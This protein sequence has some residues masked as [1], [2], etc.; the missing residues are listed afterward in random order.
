MGRGMMDKMKMETKDVTLE[1]IKRIGELF[2]SVVTEVMDPLTKR[3]NIAVDFDALKQILSGTIIEGGSERYNFTWPGKKEAIIEANRPIRKTLRPCME[4]SRNWDDTKNIFIEGDNLDALKLLQES[5]LNTVKMI[6]ID[7]P[8]N[9]G[10]DFIYNDNFSMGQ[11]KFYIANHTIDDIGNRMIHNADSNGRFHSDWCSMIYPRIKLAR[12]LL[13]DDGVIFISIDDNEQANTKKILDEVFGESNF[14]AN[15]IWKKKNVVQNDAQFVSVDHDYILCYA[16]NANALRLNHLPRTK[17]QEERYSNPDNDPRGVWTSVALQAKSGSSTY[18]IVFPNGVKWMPVKG[19]YPRLSKESLINAYEEGRIWF[20]KEG[21]NVPRLKKYLTE[22]K[23]GILSNTI[24]L[25]ETVG[26][27]QRA[28]ESLKKLMECNVFDTPKPIDLIKR[29][30][31]LSTHKDSIILDFFSGSSTTAHAVMQYNA[32]DGG[33]RSFIMVQLP[34]ICDERSEAR[35]AGFNTIADIGKERIR[36]AGKQIESD[37]IKLQKQSE[38]EKIP[39]STPDLGFRVFKIS[40]SNMKDVYYSS[41][42]YKQ[43]LLDDLINNIK[44]DR[45]HIDLL[46]GILLD[47]GLKLSLPFEIIIINSNTIYSVDKGT[48]IACFDS[49]ISEH[50]VK[51]ISKMKPTFAVFRDLSFNNIQDKI[52]LEELFKNESPETIIKVI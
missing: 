2:P 13:M 39:I 23:Q 52:N 37:I 29:M 10:K 47:W 7:P 17:E 22:V 27:T 38:L 4:E 1:N 14:I 6:Y 15:F 32:E 18:E 45:T 42:G 30:L 19:T 5:Y 9:T 16:K 43:S 51:E 8:Y 20:G 26:S 34:E 46:Y 36:R 40:D 48:M 49:N 28:K 31:Q 41:Q 24:W 44:D 35:V 12:N 33:S 50:I 11:D 21:N 25:N 3:V